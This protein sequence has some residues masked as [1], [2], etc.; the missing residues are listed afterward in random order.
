ME[1]NLVVISGTVATPPEIR[2][3][4]SGTCLI[5]YLVTVRT[6]EPR[7]RVD[8]IPVTLW[9]PTEQDLDNAQ[10]AHGRLIW[11]AGAVQRRFWSGGDGRTSRI[12][13]VAH[14]IELRDPAPIGIEEDRSSA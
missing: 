5:R 11:V 6:T 14:A 1:L 10:N 12:E 8:V 13:I 7:R 3:F 2:T 9:D 4:T